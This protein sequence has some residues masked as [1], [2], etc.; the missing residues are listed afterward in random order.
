MTLVYYISGHGFG[1][2]SRSLEVIAALHARRPDIRVVVRTEVASAFL[3]RS[4]RSPIEVELCETDTGVVQL[5]SLRID[6]D[7]TARAAARFYAT[8]DERVE[9]E[10]SHLRSLGASLVVGDAPP[11]AFAAADAAHVPS[12]GIANFTWDWIYGF[13]PQFNR[14]APG[15]LDVITQS[16][17]TASLALR[18]PLHG[19]FAPMASVTEDI[20]FIARRSMKSKG[21][22]RARL[23]VSGDRPAVIASFGA[24]GVELPFDEIARANNVALVDESWLREFRYE[25]L[26]AA[27]DV[28][29]SKPGYGIVSECAANGAALLYTSRDRFAEYD[30]FVDEMRKYIRCRYL[31]QDD[32]RQGRWADGIRAVIEQPSL[33]KPDVNGAEVAAATLDR[34]IG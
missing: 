26:V 33:P 12:V 4:K 8:F 16:Y 22:V 30:V 23:G 1:H 28:V 24:Y 14:M 34:A 20:P 29:V 19:G 25:D 10:A 13:Y 18:T 21:E 31:S 17:T 11:L 15:V 32:L 6:E 2:A 7:A 27:C 9:A 3:A 5:D